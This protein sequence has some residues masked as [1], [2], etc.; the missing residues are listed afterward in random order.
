MRDA[1]ADDFRRVPGVD[2]LTMDQ[3]GE[4]DHQHEVRRIADQSDY[5]LIVA[6]EFG[7]VLADLCTAIRQSSARLLGSDAPSLQVTADKLELFSLW[8]AR[9]VPTPYTVPV[10]QWPLWKSPVVIKPRSGAGSAFTRSALSAGDVASAV[11]AAAGDY[12]GHLIAQDLVPG[13]PASVAFLVGPAQTVPLLPTFQLLSSDGRF[14][15]EGGELPIPPPLTERAITLGLQAINCVPGLL[16]YVGVDLILGGPADGSGDFA[17]EINPRL[18]TSYV[19]LRELADFNPAEAL[20]RVVNGEP[21]APRWKPGR[22]RFRPDGV[23]SVDPTL[24]PAFA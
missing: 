17:I 24:G 16:G 23:V 9:R 4:E 19:G 2:V 1:V 11:R 22:V 7:D 8:L 14:R 12:P 10:L 13:Q 18:S 6:P 3:P 21:V 5:A 15:Y 20:L